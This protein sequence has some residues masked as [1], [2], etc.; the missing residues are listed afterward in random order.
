MRGPNGGKRGNLTLMRRGKST[1]PNVRSF[2]SAPS[3][4]KVLCA[5]NLPGRKRSEKRRRIARRKRGARSGA[6]IS[7]A[8]LHP[9]LQDTPRLIS[10]RAVAIPLISDSG[11]GI[12]ALKDEPVLEPISRWNQLQEWNLLHSWTRP[13]PSPES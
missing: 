13:I 5:R 7:E 11:I 2:V 4:G 12:A 9:F 6:A 10:I 8:A 3:S 1:P